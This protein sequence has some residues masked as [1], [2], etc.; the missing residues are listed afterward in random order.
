MD[1]DCDREHLTWCYVYAC[2]L[3]HEAEENLKQTLS[4]DHEV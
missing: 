2:V 4:S 1:L 3:A